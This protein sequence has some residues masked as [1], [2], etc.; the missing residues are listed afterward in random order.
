MSSGYKRYTNKLI[1]VI[2]IIII[3]T[4]YY[5]KIVNTWKNVGI[6]LSVPVR[7]EIDKVQNKKYNLITDA[8]SSRGNFLFTLFDF[9]LQF[10]WTLRSRKHGSATSSFVQVNGGIDG[11]LRSWIPS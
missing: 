1:V 5:C 7:Y 4:Y 10:L 3:I 2:I 6:L 11:V 9:F 8:G